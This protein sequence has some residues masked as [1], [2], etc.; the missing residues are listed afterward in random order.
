MIPIPKLKNKF[1]KDKISIGLDVGSYDIKLVK[2]KF[3]KE[4][5]E[6]AGYS[7][8]PVQK[9]PV[10]SLKKLLSSQEIRNSAISV[11][12]PS[13]IIRYVN[14][15]RMNDDELKQ[16]LKFEAQKHIPFSVSEVNLDSHILKEDVQNNKMLVLLAAVKKD[17]LTQRIKPLEDAGI[18]FNTIDIDSIALIN[19]FNFNHTAEAEEKSKTKTV[20]LLNMG[21]Q[22]S[23][24]NILEDLSPRFSRDIHVGG[25]NFVRKIQDVLGIDPS[26]AQALLIN[27]DNEKLDKICSCIESVL[28]SLA[29]EIRTSFDYYDSQGISS[30]SKIFLS[31]GIS[32]FSGIGSML[33][34]L[35]GIEVEIWDPFKK[36]TIPPGFDAQGLTPISAQFAVAVGLALHK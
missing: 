3:Q 10:E 26:Q 35:L 1:V 36:I 33:S 12:G 32:L 4:S 23:N 15:P 2:L 30:V 7:I 9:D 6:L 13:T 25:N 8:E 19:A 24:L 27:P 31:G 21:A 29:G 16:A 22:E 17:F 28:S 11:C 20:A 5:A 14:F 18:K 34:N